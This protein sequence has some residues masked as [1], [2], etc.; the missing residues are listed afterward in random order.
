M[1]NKNLSIIQN[2][3]KF[4]VTQSNDLVEAGYP[5]AM[6]ARAHKT[7]RL[8]LALISPN[9]KDLRT[10]TVTISAVKQYLG[11]KPDV[12]WGAFYKEL[13][14]IAGRLRE[15][16][17]RIKKPNGDRLNAVFLSAFEISPKQGTVTFEISGLLKPY[18]LELKKNYTSYLLT[19][20]PKLKS[21]YSIRLYELLHQYRK[22]G[23]RYFDLADL[24]EKVGSNYHDKYNN[25]KRRVL[26]QSQKDLK[27][28]TDLAFVFHEQKEGRKVVGIQFI[29]FGNTP[30]KKN[31]RQLSFLEDAFEI[32][33]KT[34]KPALSETIPQTLNELGIS[35]QNVAKY[36][37]KEFDIIEN[38][39][40]REAAKERCKTLEAYYLE[41][42]ELVKNSASKDNT[43]GFLIRALQEDWTS[44]KSFQQ[45]KAKEVAKERK[46]AQNKLKVLETKIEKLNKE[47]EAIKAPMI[48]KLIDDDAIL[49]TAY[50][51]AMNEMGEFMKKH[52]S[53]VKHL[54]IR[55]QY[56]K[57]VTINTYINIE[58]SKRFPEKFKV[59]Q[60][61]EKSIQK[62]HREIEVLKKKWRF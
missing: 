61:I 49:K 31:S 2:T 41:K 14:E 8:L 34:E 18:L 15:S 46:A 26:L 56:A 47:K 60:P 21:G 54:P 7:A 53:S 23:K 52:V 1:S 10:Y 17:I 58:L 25:F 45:L 5:T 43:A 24:Q 30:E 27:K 59:I 13:D 4:V 48:E 20:I 28:H 22:I 57:Q 19:H 16:P 55:E 12:R 29:I 50:D 9:D 37:A 51:A 36:L 3:D 6:T 42:L 35:E 33:D 40:Q 38:K 32:T 11:M 39:E 62:I 44:S